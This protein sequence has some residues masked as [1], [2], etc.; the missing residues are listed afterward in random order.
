[1]MLYTE[2]VVDLAVLDKHMFYGILTS[3]DSYDR[4]NIVPRGVL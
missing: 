2:T 4:A 1:M 3:C